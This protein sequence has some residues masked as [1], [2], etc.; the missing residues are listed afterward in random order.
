MPSSSAPLVNFS[1][2]DSATTQ[3]LTREISAF[4]SHLVKNGGPTPAEYPLLN[5]HLTNFGN[6]H[7]LNNLSAE[8]IGDLRNSLGIALSPETIQGWAYHKPLGYAGDYLLIEKIYKNYVCPN[9]DLRKWDLFSHTQKATK[10]IRNRISFFLEQMWKT[11]T[12]APMKS[13][14]LNLASGPGRDLNEALRVLGSPNIYVDCVE[15]DERAIE[16]S[17]HLCSEFLPQIQFIN[18]NALKFTSQ[19]AYH[20]IWSGGLFDYFNDSIFKRMIK[21]LYPLLE[22]DGRLIIGNFSSENPSK[23]YMDL[24]SWNLF[25]RTHDQLRALA[26]ESGVANHQISIEQEPEGINL[27]LVIQNSPA[28]QSA[29]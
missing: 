23:G 17:R 3:I 19:N 25:H 28:K 21:R 4:L 22:P 29:Q 1:A 13:R 27:F 26:E 11:H 6:P 7:F 5:Y 18:K 9:P 14:V 12:E 16:Y 24:F 2:P 10:A 20:L 15:Q 8:Q